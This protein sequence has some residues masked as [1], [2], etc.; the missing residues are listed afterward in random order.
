MK[1]ICKCKEESQI[2][3]TKKDYF[4]DVHRFDAIDNTPK[5]PP[6]DTKMKVGQII[7]IVRITIPLI[8]ILHFWASSLRLAQKK[9]R[10]NTNRDIM[11]YILY[12]V[13]SQNIH[14]VFHDLL[15]GIYSFSF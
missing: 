10:T 6:T 11:L 7:D 12:N 13:I 4:G 8:R 2:D 15:Y 14:L 1:D 5:I 9:V 3:I